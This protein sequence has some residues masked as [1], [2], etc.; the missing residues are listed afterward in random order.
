MAKT[1]WRFEFVDINKSI[2]INEV[3]AT[4]TGYAVIR[5]PKGQ[6]KAVYIPPH[7]PDM[8]NAM[9]GYASADWPDLFEL[10]DFNNEYG[11]YVSAPT[12]DVADYQIGRAHV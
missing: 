12:V 3:E 10:Q 11:V 2:T 9:F 8:I 4:W 7:N 6:T 1:T 5:A